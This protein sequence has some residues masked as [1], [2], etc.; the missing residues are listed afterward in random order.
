MLRYI[1]V[2][3]SL[4]DR[5]VFLFFSILK[6]DLVIETPKE[7]KQKLTT[8]V[9]VEDSEPLVL[10]KPEEPPMPMVPYFDLIEEKDEIKSNL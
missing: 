9:V 2:D 8:K 1:K 6:E 3:S 4:Y 10:E 7:I 5:L